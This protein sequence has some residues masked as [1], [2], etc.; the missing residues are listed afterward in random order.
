MR[1]MLDTNVLISAIV[2]RHS[3]TAEIVAHIK[4]N[5]TIVMCNR[6]IYELENIFIR[7]FPDKLYD[8]YVDI[9]ILTDELFML[10]HTEESKYPFIRDPK[11]LPVLA[12]AIE[13]QVDLFI[14]GDKDFEEIKIIKPRIL[15]PRQYKDEFM[16][17]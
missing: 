1:V 7:K 13:S 17:I 9:E 10:N 6:I 8:M 15:K 4:D 2:Y 3:I 14:T 16:I 12:N 11:D 5:H